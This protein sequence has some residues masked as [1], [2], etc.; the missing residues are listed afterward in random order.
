M[1]VTDGSR[2]AIFNRKNMVTKLLEI[3]VTVPS[4]AMHL[5]RNPVVLHP[6]VA[7]GM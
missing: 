4:L 1:Y 5:M 2:N 7:S 3:L 6:M